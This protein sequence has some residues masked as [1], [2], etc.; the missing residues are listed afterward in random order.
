MP[1]DATQVRALIERWAEAVQAGD[2]ET[3]L[4]DHA[5]DIVMFDV[6][7]P[8][9]G[10]RGIARDGEAMRPQWEKWMAE[11][12]AHYAVD[13]ARDRADVIVDGAPSIAHEP[14]SEYVRWT[15]GGP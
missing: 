7:R 9:D 6:P 11:E 12:D 3:V 1:D 13:R 4:A 5:H 15:L 10:V 14:E 2:L 8:D